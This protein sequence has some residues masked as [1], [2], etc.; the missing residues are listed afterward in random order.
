MCE[1]YFDRLQDLN[2]LIIG[3]GETGQ[4]ALRDLKKRNVNNLSIT[5]RTDEKTLD[6]ARNKGVTPILFENYKEKLHLFDVIITATG[7]GKY[8]ISKEDVQ[9][10]NNLRNTQRQ[11]FIDLSVPRNIDVEIIGLEHVDL[12]CVDDLQKILDDHKEMREKSVENADIIISE[13]VDDAITWLNSRSLRPVIKTITSNMQELSE[14][15]LYEYR[16][17]LDLETVEQLDKY[18]IKNLKEATQNGSSTSSLDTISKL[19]DFE[20]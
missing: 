20:N 8:L 5:N 6:I 4:L 18:F 13:L 2:I 10:A 17:N 11:L 12:I 14:K 15:E 3:A 7:A 1:K 9:R 16:K 19:F